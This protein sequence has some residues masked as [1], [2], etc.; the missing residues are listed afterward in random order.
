MMNDGKGT[1]KEAPC[2][3]DICTQFKGVFMRNLLLLYQTKPAADLA[4]YARH[5]S[6]AIW[7]TS[8]N[9]MDQLGYEWHLPFD[10]ATASRQSSALDGLIAAYATSGAM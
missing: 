5:Q 10:K 7:N 3:G 8:R 1:L 9:A 6:D 4:M 2:G